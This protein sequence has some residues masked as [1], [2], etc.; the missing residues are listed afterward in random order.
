MLV[1]ITPLV[2]LSWFWN[3][4]T[5]PSIIYNTWHLIYLGKLKS[6][7]YTS[8]DS[9]DDSQDVAESS[10]PVPDGRSNIIIELSTQIS[11]Q[12]HTISTLESRLAE[13][14]KIIERLNVGKL[15]P[16]DAKNIIEIEADK[17]NQEM[18][19]LAKELKMLKRKKKRSKPLP[20]DLEN[21][22]D[23]D[24]DRELSSL[25]RDSGAV[26]MT[27]S[28]RNS[29]KTRQRATDNTDSLDSFS[30]LT[31]SP[32]AASYTSPSSLVTWTSCPDKAQSYISCHKK[33]LFD[34]CRSQPLLTMLFPD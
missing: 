12:E 5:L 6:T 3:T 18:H 2:I 4:S 21:N 9:D 31:P 22:N 1:S 10:S 23:F 29:R 15:S 32:L 33:V 25:S 20:H 27:S 17:A 24:I 30:L 8:H 11:D 28:S 34:I 7:G 19:A 26:D 16:R 14:D 13:K